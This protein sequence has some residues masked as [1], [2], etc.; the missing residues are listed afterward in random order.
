MTLRTLFFLAM[1]VPMAARAAE[2]QPVPPGQML[3]GRFTQER[4]LSGMP[5]PLRSEGRFLLVPGQ[6]LI[7]RAEKPFA[8][9]T[10]ISPSGLAQLVEGQQTLSMP[11]S[12]L[13]FL[14]PFYDML[15]GALAGDWRA[16]E[17]NFTVT[18]EDSG[19]MWTVRL[20]PKK[21]DPVNAPFESI[22]LS[23]K[24]FVETVDIAK[25]GGDQER[26][27]FTD[28]TLSPAAVPPDDARL[29]GSVGQ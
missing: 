20:V 9:V 27:V 12:R 8:T 22:H 24:S 19:S 5:K 15:S 3:Q 29:F 17:R 18:R 21:A 16:I 11:A 10:V 7:W 4:Q 25:T 6:G 13:P 23:G 28:Q 1:L 14:R 2:P 26:L